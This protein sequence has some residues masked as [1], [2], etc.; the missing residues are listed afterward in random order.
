MIVVALGLIIMG[1]AIGGVPSLL[2]TARADAGLTE[3]AAALR[4]SRESSI[5]NR[6]NVQLTFGSNTITATRI[7]YCPATC[8]TATA[9]T[10]P[11]CTSTCT[12]KTTALRTVTLEGRQQ[13][14]LVTSPDL[15]DT[16][17]T[18]GNATATAFGSFTPPMFTTDGSFINSQGD[19][20]NGSL[21]IS[22]PGDR[23]SARA[24]TIFGPTGAM[25]LWRWNG[26]AW[27]EV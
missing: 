16:P 3:L 13:F 23:T 25:H 14:L 17:D 18:F 24:I 4:F 19:V 26:K 22:I 11:G 20:L 6:R 21:F 7:E 2:K 5:S 10:F 9:S 15:P 27:V 8:T 12:A 1:M